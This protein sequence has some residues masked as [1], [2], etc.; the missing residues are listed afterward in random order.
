M[1][2]IFILFITLIFIL[3]CSR[4]NNGNMP[5]TIEKT[6]EIIEIIETNDD[7]IV[8]EF[9]SISELG[10][11]QTYNY[12]DGNGSILYAK[13]INDIKW[14][15]RKHEQVTR[16]YNMKSLIAYEQPGNIGEK[17]FGIISGEEIN[18]YEM[19]I[20]VNSN[21]PEYWL[22]ISNKQGENGWIYG[23][24]GDPY[25]NEYGVVA[26]IFNIE[27]IIWTARIIAAESYLAADG[28]NVRDRPGLIDTN[29]IFQ[30]R[31][32]DYGEAGLERKW[33]DYYYE[34]HVRLLLI[35]VEKDTINGVT[36]HWVKIKD[37]FN[38][39]GWVFGGFLEMGDRGGGKY[40]TP[41]LFVSFD[42]NPP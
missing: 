35:T 25:K 16:I 34:M 20:K 23:G 37:K 17:L 39:E 24:A 38:N 40:L 9:I 32:E 11:F 5:E 22:K 26:E 8:T 18:I 36:E 13:N 33:G 1:K 31:K 19:A 12:D 42:L 4:K 30:I 10:N 27:N 28:L 41:E 3:G 7:I 14:I 29:I 6:E 21:H 15:F 2:N